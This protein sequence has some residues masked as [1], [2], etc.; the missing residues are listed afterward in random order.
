MSSK[1]LGVSTVEFKEEK[2]QLWF[3]RSEIDRQF[4]G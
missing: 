3:M 4:T 2:K 1:Q